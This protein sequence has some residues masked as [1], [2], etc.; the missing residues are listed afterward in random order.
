MAVVA[1]RE[2]VQPMNWSLRDKV[3]R[4]NGEYPRGH[5]RGRAKISGECRKDKIQAQRDEGEGH[6]T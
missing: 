2:T 6:E 1:A 5:Y 3:Q 4:T